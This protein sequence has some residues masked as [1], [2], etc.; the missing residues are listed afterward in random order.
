[1]PAPGPALND[2]TRVAEQRYKKLGGQFTL[3][4]KEGEGHY[5]LNPT[6]AKPVVEF[7]TKS[8]SAKP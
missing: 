7:I 3:I 2:Q 5:P 1:M 6:D 4:L 8:I